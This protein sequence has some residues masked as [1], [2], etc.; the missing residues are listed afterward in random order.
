MQR[1]VPQSSLVAAE[2]GNVHHFIEISA[3]TSCDSLLLRQVYRIVQL[4][5]V[6]VHNF[7]QCPWLCCIILSTALYIRQVHVFIALVFLSAGYLGAGTTAVSEFSSAVTRSQTTY[8]GTAPGCKLK[9][10]IQSS[11]LR[12]VFSEDGMSVFWLITSEWLPLAFSFVLS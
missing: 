10:C 12:S 6:I 8:R 2:C 9:R 1:I 3:C 4:H 7:S 11:V 5:S